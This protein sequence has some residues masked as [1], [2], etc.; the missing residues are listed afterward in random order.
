MMNPFDYVNSINFSKKD[1]MVDDIAEKSYDSFL[2][3]RALSYFIDTALL[4]NEMN[5]KH[6]LDKKLQ[7]HFLIN[8]V[9]KGKRYSKW[10]KADKIPDIEVVKEYFG[11]NNE[12]AIEALNLLSD[13]QIIELRNKVNKGGTRKSKTS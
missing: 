3:N 2:T 9:R 1:L 11:Y 5:I 8:T 12:R 10:A 7:Y 13:K 6:H 4:A